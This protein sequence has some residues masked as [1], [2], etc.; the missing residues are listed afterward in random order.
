[1]KSGNLRFIKWSGVLVIA[2]ISA[3]ATT[4]QGSFSSSD[5]MKLYKLFQISELSLSSD[6]SDDGANEANERIKKFYQEAISKAVSSNNGS[7]VPSSLPHSPSEKKI[8]VVDASLD[9]HYGSRALRYWV[10][11]GAGKGYAKIT[12]TAKDGG[13]GQEK[14]NDVRT[15]ELVMGTFGG[16]FEA[17]IKAKMGEQIQQFTNNLRGE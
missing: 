9:V 14:Y 6:Q 4:K 7:I 11:F 1:M 10:G 3:C 12:L 2:L 8:L 5:D 15:V 17:M 13:T 16:S